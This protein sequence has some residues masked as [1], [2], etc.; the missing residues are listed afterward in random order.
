M[1]PS[2]PAGGALRQTV[3]ATFGLKRKH[4]WAYC[5][6]FGQ[7]QMYQLVTNRRTDIQITDRQTHM[8]IGSTSTVLCNFCVTNCVSAPLKRLPDPESL[9]AAFCCK[10]YK[11]SPYAGSAVYRLA[12]IFDT[13]PHYFAHPLSAVVYRHY[14][15]S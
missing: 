4:S 14:H 9:S 13:A 10:I 11:I 1:N 12:A 15:L 6:V 5:V 2:N 8:P 7:V 3:L